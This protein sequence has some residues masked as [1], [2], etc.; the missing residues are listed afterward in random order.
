MDGR[1]MKANRLSALVLV[2]APCLA[3]EAGS[4][5]DPTLLDVPW[6]G[7]SFAR[8]A[9]RGYLETVPAVDF[10]SGLGVVWSSSPPGKSPDRVAADLA[11]AGFERVRIE[12][13]WGAVRADEDGFKD[14]AAAELSSKLRALKAHG[15]RPMILLNAN[16]LEP[17][18]AQ[19]RELRVEQAAPAGSLAVVVS[20]DLRGIEPSRATLM[21]LADGVT[22]G[23]MIDGYS[24]DRLH[25]IALSKELPRAVREGEVLRLA[26]LAYA[27]LHPVGTPEFERTAAG[28]LR[29][30]DLAAKLVERNYGPEFDVEIWNEFTFGSGFLSIDNYLSPQRRVAGPEPFHE[31]GRIW[32]LASR[33]VERLR[34]RHPGALPIWGLSSTSFFHVPVA[35]LPP[36]IA[37]QTYHPYGT[38]RLCFADAVKNKSQR[39]LDHDM[40][41]GCITQPEGW[42]L[43]WY[44]TESLVR[45]IAPGPR[46]ARPRGSAAFAHFI[47][48]HGF[49]PDEVGIADARAAQRAKAKFLLRAPLLWLNKGIRALYVYDAYDGNALGCGMID[50]NGDA[51]DALRALH[52]LTERLSAATEITEPRRLA[53][54]LARVGAAAERTDAARS[55]PLDD[56]V[57]VLPFQL[58]DRA[59][60]LG[61]YVMTQNF[62]ADL[63]PQ[64]YA[65]TVSGVRGEHAVVSAYSPE[66]GTVEPV[67]VVAR[68]EREIVVELELTDVP[69][70][71]EI[72]EPL[73][74]EPPGAPG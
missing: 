26:V 68:S 49:R 55:A 67:R 72:D 3:V 12:V 42:A 16:H 19:W 6:G 38:G 37:G 33:T 52:N 27:P 74:V 32:E 48:E 62:P 1:A 69:R 22:P 14:G 51:G 13:P 63:P 59:F 18:P 8:Q 25:T 64:P 9:W 10:L 60:A 35:D 47:T 65:I 46:A 70:L 30:V 23:P 2:V 7:F 24:G 50:P 71:I 57:A 29:Y 40:P 5:T 39:L 66:S 43:S 44:Q 45:L 61:A 28:W 20:G 36:G 31:G 54:E 4:Y 73:G 21:S 56:L 53:I 58:T 41:S 15:L 17:C 34:E 11:W